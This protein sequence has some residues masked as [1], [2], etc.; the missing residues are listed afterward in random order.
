[1]QEAPEPFVDDNYKERLFE[2]FFSS[3]P[4]SFQGEGIRSQIRAVYD[5]AYKA[6]YG[7]R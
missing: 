3:L 4:E 2:S 6:H 7:V 1:M 5:F